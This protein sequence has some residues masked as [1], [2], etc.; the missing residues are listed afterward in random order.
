MWK[1]IARKKAKRVITECKACNAHHCFAY[2]PRYHKKLPGGPITR[3]KTYSC[4]TVIECL[5]EKL[6]DT[7]E[8]WTE[9]LCGSWWL[10]RCTALI[11]DIELCACLVGSI[12]DIRIGYD[13]DRTL[14]ATLYDFETVTYA[15]FQKLVGAKWEGLAKDLPPQR[16]KGSFEVPYQ[17]S[18]FWYILKQLFKEICSVPTECTIMHYVVGL[19]FF[20]QSRG[21][22]RSPLNTLLFWDNNSIPHKQLFV[23]FIFTVFQ[24][25]L[26]KVKKNCTRLQTL[27]L[28]Y[29]CN[30]FPVFFHCRNKSCCV[31]GYPN[32]SNE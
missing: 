11:I 23:D 24:L 22:Q 27:L 20:S 29:Y 21:G 17:N 15:W 25:V 1:E 32:E 5:P 6:Q 9:P 2:F 4:E 18:A 3:I 12:V 16:G 13:P 10:L 28:L 7:V 14:S 31:A 30:L 8:N 19:L 26:P